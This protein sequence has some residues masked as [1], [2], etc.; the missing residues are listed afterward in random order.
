MV[1]WSWWSWIWYGSGV[2]VVVN[3]EWHRCRGGREYG[4]AS[5][6]WWSWIKY[7]SGVVNMVWDRGRGGREYGMAVKTAHIDWSFLLCTL[8][9]EVQRWPFH[10]NHVIW[11]TKITK[12]WRNGNDSKQPYYF[13][14]N[15]FRLV[16]TQKMYCLLPNPR[17]P[18]LTGLSQATDKIYLIMLYRIH[19]AM[20][21]NNK[22]LTIALNFRNIDLIMQ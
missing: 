18:L 8:T 11:R 9:P 1:V 2:V 12:F 15:C 17:Q 7:G 13:P 22:S 10:R 4:M 16:Y 5:V 6:S 21:G 19:I 3:M 20:Y 14:I